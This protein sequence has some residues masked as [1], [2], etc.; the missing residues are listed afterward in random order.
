M[1]IWIVCGVWAY[2]GK[3][4]LKAFRTKEGAESFINERRSYERDGVAVKGG[5][6]TYF[7]FLM[8]EEIEM[9]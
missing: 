4:I 3:R 7:D 9:V 8:I 6:G 2:E 1:K 5:D